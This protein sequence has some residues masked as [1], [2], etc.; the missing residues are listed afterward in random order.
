MTLAGYRDQAA[1]DRR[2][3]AHRPGRTGNYSLASGGTSLSLSLAALEDPQTADGDKAAAPNESDTSGHSAES[4]A[5]INNKLNNPGADVA[6]LN[7]KLTWNQYEGRLGTREGPSSQNSVALLFQPVIPFSLSNGAH[8]IA[9]PTIPVVWQPRYNAGTGGFDED[10]GLADSV[11][12][13]FYAR[14]DKEK[15]IMWGIGG[16]AGFPTHTDDW[17]GKDQFQLGP[18]AFIGRFGKWGST[19]VFPQ[20]L[21]NIGGSS[22]GYTSQTQIQAWYWFNVGKGYQVGGAPLIVYD[23]AIDDSDDA[24]VVPVNLGV[25]KTVRIGKLPVKF[26]VEGIYY[27]EQPDSFGPHWGL[28]FTITPVIP[29]PFEKHASANAN[30]P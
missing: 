14:T 26:K 13:V 1:D 16:A 9:R 2:A 28:Q 25:A 4:L 3:A 12:D 24:W 29:N 17:L 15:G 18:A 7:F 20:H 21:W 22:E 11:I 5:E 8:I 30:E 10:F 19:G 23:W 27:A 6:Q